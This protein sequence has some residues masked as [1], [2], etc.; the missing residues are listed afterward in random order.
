MKY[1]RYY[2]NEII[3]IKYTRK[4]NQET[5]ELYYDNGQQYT[6]ETY[7]NGRKEGLCESWY[8]NGNKKDTYYIKNGLYYGFSKEW[9]K[10]GKI[11]QMVSYL[12]GKPHGIRKEWYENGTLKVDN[13]GELH[14]R[15]YE[16]GNMEKYEDEFL[17]KN[18]YENGLPEFKGFRNE[19]IIYWYENNQLQSKTINNINRRTFWYENGNKRLKIKDGLVKEW[20][21]DG[22]IK[23]NNQLKHYF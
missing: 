20:H 4:D 10:N 2:S 17:S 7:L 19:M 18:W 5:N 23:S 12:Y 11:K 15:W 16:N 1:K 13:N 22:R 3:R 14:T 6:K 8:K 9:Y 21:E